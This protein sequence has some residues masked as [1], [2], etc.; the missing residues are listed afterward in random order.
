MVGRYE[1]SDLDV[2][3]ILVFAPNAHV[4]LGYT[5]HPSQFE[6]EQEILAGVHTNPMEKLVVPFAVAL[7][8]S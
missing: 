2:E 3:D 4:D 1:V 7:I 5:P 6:L 8:C